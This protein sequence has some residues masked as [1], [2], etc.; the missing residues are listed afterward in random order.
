MEPHRPEAE[1]SRRL[2]DK[3]EQVGSTPTW[4]TG[5]PAAFLG[6]CSATPWPRRHA[7]KFGGRAVAPCDEAMRRDGILLVARRGNPGG[8][9]FESGTRNDSFEPGWRRQHLPRRCSRSVHQSWRPRR[10]KPCPASSMG[11]H[12]SYKQGTV[13]RFHR[14]VRTLMRRDGLLLNDEVVGSN[15]TRHSR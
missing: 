12:L 6:S 8:R 14:W 9:R 13:V 4:S 5:T 3:E 7:S 15:P 1:R 11:E 10:S 2:S